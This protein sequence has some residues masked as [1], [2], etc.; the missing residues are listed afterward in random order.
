MLRHILALLA[1]ILAAPALAQDDPDGTTAHGAEGKVR[2]ADSDK[3]RPVFTVG[4][5]TPRGWHVRS[6]DGFFRPR[7]APW[8]LQAGRVTLTYNGLKQNEIHWR[9]VRVNTPIDDKLF[10][11]PF[12]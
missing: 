2:I 10:A 5:A 11:P 3:G 7:D 1:L 12:P 4:F 8:W 9:A 6:Y